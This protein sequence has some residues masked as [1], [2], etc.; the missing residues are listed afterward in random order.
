MACSTSDRPPPL[1]DGPIMTAGEAAEDIAAAI[2]Q[3]K[4]PR[5]LVTGGK[6][7]TALLG[8]FIQKWVYPEFVERKFMKMFGLQ[9][10]KAASA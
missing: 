1:Q 9:G 4:P 3:R 2:M 8:G 7:R 10:L 6:A 5:E